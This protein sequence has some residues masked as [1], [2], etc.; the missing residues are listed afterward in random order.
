MG[1]GFRAPSRILWAFVAKRTSPPILFEAALPVGQAFGMSGEGDAW[2]KLAV[3][4]GVGAKLL[5][6]NLHRLQ[7]CTFVVRIEGVE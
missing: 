4:A 6:D 7:H 3:P 2:R 5:S 1:V